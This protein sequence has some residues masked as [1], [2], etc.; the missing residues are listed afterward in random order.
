MLET[1]LSGQ[2]GTM[3][4]QI[5]PA[6]FLKMSALSVK[7]MNTKYTADIVEV[8]NQTAAA[9]GADPEAN[10]QAGQ[11]AAGGNQS[12]QPQSRGLK[13]PQ[14]TNEGAG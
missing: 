12:A 2:V 5:N 9:L 4:S 11:T 1:V 6:G 8:L 14:N 3:M 10:A 13:L 7:S